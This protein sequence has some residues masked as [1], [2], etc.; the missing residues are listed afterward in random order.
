MSR[1]QHATRLREN[2]EP[3]PVA[4]GGAKVIDAKYEVVGGKRGWLSNWLGKLWMG[5]LAILTAAL[6]GFLIPPVWIIMRE[7]F[8][9]N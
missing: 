3:P 6:V 9:A 8:A 7:I 1:R 2:T 5:L 4:T